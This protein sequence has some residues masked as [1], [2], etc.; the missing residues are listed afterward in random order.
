MKKQSGAGTG[1]RRA[2]G[3]RRVA[4]TRRRAADIRRMA[5]T[6]CRTAEIVRKTKETSISL[7]LNV[8]GSGK[9]AIRTPIGFFSHMLEAFAKHGLF[10]LEIEASGDLEVDQHHL[11]EDCG[12]VLGQAFKEA[13]G[14]KKGINRA[15][16]F[17]FPMDEALAI[18]AVDISARPFLQYD[19]KFGRRFCGELDTD[20]LADFFQGFASSLGA[21]VAISIPAGRSDHHKIEALFKAFAKA[22][23]MACSRDPRAMGSLPSTKG[24]I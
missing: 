8:D 22:M 7:K 24:A 4:S 20:V 6:S 9:Y 3:I 16:Y 1:S 2:A 17:V 11:V 23:K 5:S 15:G 14:D 21:N 18:V 10:D 13:L 12:I 19:A